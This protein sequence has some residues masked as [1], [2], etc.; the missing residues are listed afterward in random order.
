MH[1]QSYCQAVDAHAKTLWWQQITRNSLCERLL[2]FAFW[3][4]D[5]RPAWKK[6]AVSPLPFSVTP[7]L[8]RG[9]ARCANRTTAPETPFGRQVSLD[10]GKDIGQLCCFLRP[11]RRRRTS[12]AKLPRRPAS[13]RSTPRRTWKWSRTV[14]HHLGL[15]R[16]SQAGRYGGTFDRREKLLMKRD[17]SIIRPEI[18]PPFSTRNAPSLPAPKADLALLQ[19]RPD[20][21]DRN[22]SGDIKK[23]CRSRHAHFLQRPSWA[24]S[25]KDSHFPFTVT[26]EAIPA[27]PTFDLYSHQRGQGERSHCQ[28]A[29]LVEPATVP[30][31]VARRTFRFP[32]CR[33]PSTLFHRPST[34]PRFYALV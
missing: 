3:R 30:G 25:G 33:D 1:D 23:D 19:N 34:R 9:T 7:H 18:V 5:E 21:R 26:A 10:R 2:H 17:V 22:C 13:I 20:R 24:F 31:S 16:S 4:S 14:A 27:R 12:C 6:S 32:V 28:C 11:A 8:F 29:R 15:G